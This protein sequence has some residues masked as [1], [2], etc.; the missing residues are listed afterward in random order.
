MYSKNA[1]SISYG[2]IFL[3]VL[4]AF[5]GIFL[6]VFNKI[7][8]TTFILVNISVALGII[9]QKLSIEKRKKNS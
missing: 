9:A 6:F 4:V 2:F 3:F 8:K 5:T 7:D 1:N